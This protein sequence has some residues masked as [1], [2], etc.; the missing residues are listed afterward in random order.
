MGASRLALP[1]P[2]RRRSGAP[3]PYKRD[4]LFQARCAPVPHQRDPRFQAQCTPCNSRNRRLEIYHSRTAGQPL[5][6][7]RNAPPARIPE[8]LGAAGGQPRRPR[9]FELADSPRPAPAPALALAL[10]LARE[11]LTS[12]PFIPT[13]YGVVV[14]SRRSP[15]ALNRAVHAS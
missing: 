15:R 8:P 6:P 1:A 7:A 14:P 10:A 9:T 4:P 3:V 2:A 11:H 5:D 12:Q 13:L